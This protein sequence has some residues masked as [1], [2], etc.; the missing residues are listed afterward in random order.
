MSGSPMKLFE[1]M[2]ASKAIVATALP[3]IELIL[4]HRQN[5]LLVPPAD[6]DAMATAIGDLLADA[7]LRANLGQRARQDVIDNYS[8]NS[9]VAKVEDILHRLC[10]RTARSG[11]PARLA[12]ST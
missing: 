10:R 8:W 5:G 3:N 9:T 4:T 2:A 7:D 1:Y 6:A 11:A 12:P